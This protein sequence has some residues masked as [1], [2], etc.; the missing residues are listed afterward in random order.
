MIETVRTPTEND[1]IT[2]KNLDRRMTTKFAK[3]FELPEALPQVLRGLAR[4]I[5]RN[6]P[7]DINKFGK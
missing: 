3:D 5:L 1:F 2:L 4:E 7:I 6:Q